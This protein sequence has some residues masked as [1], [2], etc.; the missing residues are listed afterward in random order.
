MIAGAVFYIYNFQCYGRRSCI[1]TWTCSTSGLSFEREGRVEE[2]RGRIP[3][4]SVG[5]VGRGQGLSGQLVG[6]GGDG[7][8]GIDLMHLISFIMQH[9]YTSTRTYSSAAVHTYLQ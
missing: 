2:G 9:A 5:W 8:Q 4:P 3:R 7:G 6:E 1:C